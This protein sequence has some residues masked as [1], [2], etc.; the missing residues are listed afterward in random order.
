MRG[1]ER[2]RRRRRRDG[3]A[4]RRRGAATTGSVG[5]TALEAAQ[6]GRHK[7]ASGTIEAMIMAA[8]AAQAQG[9]RVTVAE[10]EAAKER[11]SKTDDSEAGFLRE[12]ARRPSR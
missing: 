9:R 12:E 6:E 4:V 5:K 3:A 2:Q 1:G 11:G 8:S 7:D 10:L